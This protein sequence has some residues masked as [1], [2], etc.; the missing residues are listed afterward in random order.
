MSIEEMQK[1][2][3]ISNYN[4]G[5]VDM[6]D[7][8]I[9]DFIYDSKEIYSKNEIL[10]ILRFHKDYNFKCLINGDDTRKEE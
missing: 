8:I 2:L 1:S 4:N 7:E 10:K 5:K 9:D 6:V 3:Y